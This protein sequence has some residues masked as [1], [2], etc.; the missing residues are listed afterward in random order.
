VLELKGEDMNPEILR[1]VI[2]ANLE[3]G[4]YDAALA[5]A[6]RAQALM[7]DDAGLWS[8]RSDIYGRME[9]YDDAVAALN[10]ALELDPQ[11]PNAYLRRG[12]LKLRS[13]DSQGGTA[14]LQT[15]VD[16]GADVEVV[17]GQLLA[18]GYNDF[19]K[20]EQYGEALT[21]FEVGTDLASAGRVRDQLYFFTAY[22]YY[23]VGVAIDGSNEANEACQPARRALSN[24]Q[25]VLPNLDRAGAEQP[26]SQAQIR[27]S[28]DIYIYRQ[29]QIIRKNC[30]G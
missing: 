20:T 14:D 28:T 24:F 19:F 26:Q 8:I 22:G 6:D 16:Q 13:G 4:D 11:Y 7:P 2:A 15:A 1:N 23:Q 25:K 10:R 21:M 12:F 27:E 5:F 29:E 17:A 3:L 9:R 18:R 30:G